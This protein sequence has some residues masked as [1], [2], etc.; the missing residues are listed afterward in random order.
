MYVFARDN[1][2]M[3]ENKVVSLLKE[4]RSKT[5]KKYPPFSYERYHGAQAYVDE[6]KDTLKKLK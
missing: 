4:Y 3:D 6:L 5:G 1:K 2:I